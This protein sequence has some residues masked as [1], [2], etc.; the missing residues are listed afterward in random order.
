MSV[1]TDL[2]LKVLHCVV[3]RRNVHNVLLAPL[4]INSSGQERRSV[5]LLDLF[6][7]PCSSEEKSTPPST[8]RR[9]LDDLEGC[10][11]RSC[12]AVL[13]DVL[14]TLSCFPLF[15]QFIACEFVASF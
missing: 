10:L 15:H 5:H 4:I 2:I 11:K 3:N 12:L 13:E 7:S 14:S 8:L 1:W 6:T 9:I